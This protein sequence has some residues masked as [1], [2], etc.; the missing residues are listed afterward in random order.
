MHLFKSELERLEQISESF[1]EDEANRYKGLS[2]E[3]LYTSFDDLIKI[4]QHPQVGGIWVD[5]GGGSGR[6]CLLYSFITKKPSINLEIDP[7]RAEIGNQLAN[8]F[9]LNS[10]SIVCDLLKDDI[11]LADTYFLYFPTGPV[12]DRVLD[13]LAHRK[14]FTLV[15]IESH[16]DLIPRI[17]K[18]ADYELIDKILL[19]TPRHDPYVH[20]YRKVRCTKTQLGP[21]HLSFKDKLLVLEDQWGE[22]V[23]NSFGL[24]WLADDRYQFIHPPRTIEWAKEFKRILEADSQ[25]YDLI[26][27]L[28][29][30]R[31]CGEVK[32]LL[33]NGEEL[34]GEIRKIRI[35]FPLALEISTSELIEWSKVDKII[36]GSHLCYDSSSCSFLHPAP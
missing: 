32:I 35:S 23:A 10:S 22:W 24:E 3:A 9:N 8:K 5:I 7:A 33:K 25:D 14:D 1:V 30:I 34:S 21:H 6:S 18:E 28:C 11:P 4:Y 19:F 27:N 31:K 29:D 12:L 26:K 15:V 17:K 13:V 20:I 16:G 2:L 36:Q